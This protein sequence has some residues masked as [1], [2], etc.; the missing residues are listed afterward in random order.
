MSLALSTL[1]LIYILSPGFA[2]RY[3]FFR[4]PFSRKMLSTSVSDDVFWSVVPAFFIQ[5]SGILLLRSFGLNPALKEIYL[6]LSSPK[7][8]NFK[9]IEEGLFPFLAYSSVVIGCSF[10]LGIGIRK[11]IFGYNLDLKYNLLNDNEWYYLLT[12]KQAKGNVDFIQLALLVNTSKGTALYT[13]I[14]EDFVLN[15]DGAIDRLSLINVHRNTK[16]RMPGDHFII[17]GKEILNINL[18]YIEVGESEL[19]SGE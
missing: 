5:I 10:L 11:L 19:S 8:V 13:G 17:F 12:G 15:K 4:G 18:T 7:S 6:L 3:A 2:F 1:I 9:I 16:Y 14:L